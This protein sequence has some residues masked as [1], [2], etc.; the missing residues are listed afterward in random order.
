MRWYAPHLMHNHF[1]GTSVIFFFTIAN[2]M[3][4]FRSLICTFHGNFILFLP[5][6]YGHVFDYVQS[7][8][9][10]LITFLSTFF[11]IHF[12]QNDPIYVLNLNTLLFI[13]V[14]LPFSAINLIEKSSENCKWVFEMN[15]LML[16]LLLL[17]LM[18]QFIC[19]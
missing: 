1:S 11:G 2:E 7:E 8:I 6:D 14:R 13:L 9:L 10:L 4:S 18:L 19:V 3:R 12:W 5:C 15:S 17:P 16:W